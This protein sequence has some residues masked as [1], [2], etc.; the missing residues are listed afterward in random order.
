MPTIPIH[1]PSSISSPPCSAV[2]PLLCTPHGL[3]L[4][5][6]Q[7]TLN[8]PSSLHT[9]PASSRPPIATLT[10]PTAA[11]STSEP[12]AWQKQVYLYVGA[13]QRMSGEVR[14]LGRPL[15]VV[16]RRVGVEGEGEELEIVEVVRWKVVFGGRPEPVG[17]GEE[18]GKT[19]GEAEGGE[20]EEMVED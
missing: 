19:E 13:N 17:V 20:G 16:R 18:E 5:E 14:K 3:L 11:F 8:I 2:P 12:G 1:P 15:A 6:L 10:F 7:G 9:L 4:L